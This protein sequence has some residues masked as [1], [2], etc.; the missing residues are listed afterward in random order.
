MGSEP[1]QE[2]DLDLAQE[3]DDLF[4][5][6]DFGEG[7]GFEAELSTAQNQTENQKDRAGAIQP[8][9]RE[10]DKG[11]KR[12]RPTASD[13]EQDSE[14]EDEVSANEN[15]S[16]GTE[17]DEAGTRQAPP[18]DAEAERRLLIMQAMTE[19]Q[20]NRSESWRRSSLARPKMKKLVTSLLGMSIN[21]KLVI[22]M[23]G[24]SKLYVGE[25]IETARVLAEREGHKGPLLP[26][27]IQRAYQVLSGCGRIPHT[28]HPSRRVFPFRKP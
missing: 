6:V 24:I 23:C 22:A 9:P 16:E 21:D 15:N 17:S 12:V 11:K 13:A 8:V 27:H 26:S 19:A 18:R 2:A 14:T 10:A 5:D 28:K 25:L 3:L 20:L 4:A 1:D 7:S